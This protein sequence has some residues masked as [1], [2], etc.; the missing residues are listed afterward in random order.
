MIGVDSSAEMLERA[1]ATFPAPSWLRRD[2]TGWAASDPVDV[3]Y[4]NAALHW[5]EDHD[6]L[7][8]RLFRQVRP[9]GV[10]AFQMPANWDEPTHRIPAR[11]LDGGDWPER[12]RRAL[13]RDRVAAPGHYRRLLVDGAS[14][15]DLWE[16]VYHQE[17]RGDDPVLT[18]VEGSVLR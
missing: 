1:R 10:F 3:L 11:I 7:L 6:H 8:P 12:A 18:W 16:T 5:L 13:V 9:G 14:S 4:S 17:L 2:I 15:L